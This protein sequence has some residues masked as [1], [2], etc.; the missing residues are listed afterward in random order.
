MDR[1]SSFKVVPRHVSQVV[2]AVSKRTFWAE[3]WI[4]DG[5]AAIARTSKGPRALAWVE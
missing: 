1:G 4:G 5:V 3:E 2:G